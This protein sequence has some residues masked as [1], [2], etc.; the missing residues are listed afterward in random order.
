MDCIKLENDSSLARIFHASKEG[1]PVDVYINDKLVFSNIEFK[2]FSKYIK[3]KE[4]NYRVDVYEYEKT[5]KPLLNQTV[6]INPNEVYTISIVGDVGNLSLLVIND[7]VSK[8][9]NDDY[10]S[11]RVINLSANGS[12]I[13]IVV[14]GD[15]L[16]KDIGYKQG[17]IY[18]DVKINEYNMKI[19]DSKDDKTLLKF[20]SKFNPNKIYTLYLVGNKEGSNVIKSVDGNTY[21]FREW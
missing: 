17:T 10:S 12:P 1:P 14:D 20:K 2:N 4:G 18:A 7:Y 9:M 5:E 3:L 13:D 16:F 6:Q 15:I 8:T 21:I 19:I 11:F